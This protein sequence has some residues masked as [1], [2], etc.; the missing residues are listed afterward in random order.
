MNFVGAPSKC[1]CDGEARWVGQTQKQQSLGIH[2]M[3]NLLLLA[4]KGFLPKGLDS[5]NELRDL[6]PEQKSL[7]ISIRKQRQAL[8][9]SFRAGSPGGAVAASMAFPL[10]LPPVL[11]SGCGPKLSGWHSVLGQ[12]GEAVNRASKR[13]SY[14]Q[15][16]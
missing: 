9:F 7:F 14:P 3:G 1:E 11:T 12:P 8:A 4:G 10:L 2:S 13:P 16:F 5:S 6:N 15:L